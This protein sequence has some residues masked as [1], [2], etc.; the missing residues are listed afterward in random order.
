[1]I[2]VPVTESVVS[3]TLD[4]DVVFDVDFEV[5]GITSFKANDIIK[6][7]DEIMLI[8]NVGVGQTNNFK[9]L[10]AQL[11]TKVASHSNGTTVELLGGNYNIVDNTVHFVSA[12][13]GGI[14]IGT[15]TDGPDEIDW[16]GITTYSTFQGRTF[17]RSG[18]EDTDVDTYSSNYTFDNIQKDFNGQKN[19]F[20]LL[21]N[22][23]NVIG[24]AT[25]QAIVLNSNILQEPQGAQSTTGDFTLGEVAGVTSITYLGDSVSSEDDPNRATI[26]RG[27]TII[28]VASTPGLGF[29]PLIS[30]GA[31]CFVSAGGTITSISIGNSGSGYRTGVGTINVGYAVSSTGITTVVNIG[32]ATVQNGHVVAITTNYFGANLDQNYPPV[33]VIDAPLPYSSIP[34]VYNEGTTGIG[35]GAK[36]DVKVGQGSSIIEFEIVSGGFGYGVSEELRLSIGGTT[37]IQ[38]EGSGSFD[39]F[40][41][42]V[43][44]VYRDTFNGFTVGELDVFDKLDDQFDGVNRS[45]PLS[46]AGNLFAIETAEGSNINIAQCLIVTIN[47]I[48]QVPN[49]A[50]KFNG[51]SLIEF[52]EAPK[53]GDSSKIIF[54]KGTPDVDVVLV[55]ILETVKIGDTLQLKNDSSLGQGF[56]FFQ[57]ERIVTGITTLD[58]VRT[59]PY[60][61]PGITT[62]KSLVRPITWCK[63]IDDISVNGSFVTKDRVDY[64]PS[65]YPA[66]YITS[67]VGVNSTQVYTDTTRPFFNSSNETSLLDYQDR[68]TIVDQSSIVGAVA[69]VT[70]STAGTVTGFTLS[71]VGAGYSTAT[72]SI[73]QPIDI[74]GGTR[75]TATASV[76]AGGTI[77]G[78]TI[79]NA[80]AGYSLSNPPEVLISVPKSRRE[81][82]GVNSY[83]GDQGIIVG[84]A[85][86]SGALGT[87]ELYIPQ[88]SFMRDDDIVG[89]GI[90][91]S[92]LNADDLFVVNLSSFGLSTNTSDGIYRVSKAYDFVTDLNSV[93]LGTTAIRRVEVENVGFGATVAGFTR[94]KALGEY[95]WGKIQFKN[96]VA[97]NAL[98]FTPNGYSGLTTSPVVQ[99][100]RPLKFNNY[101]T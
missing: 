54:Y 69:T 78:F 89:T 28:S 85:Q 41:L 36:V 59:F 46:I 61:G 81:V 30:A 29:Q 86:S 98:T 57:E 25:N 11:G 77:S 88:D 87:L 76:S 72:V 84:Y 49:Q 7:D 27:G 58:T 44:D 68:I 18:I 83:F 60:D 51:G 91:L 80:G 42:T 4:Q 99:R 66:A 71:N 95:T 5:T 14:P 65:I 13:F 31:S 45:F 53:K 16:S 93:G 20:S 33:I 32:T 47:D 8:Q 100:L 63:Q 96:R 75:A 94:G 2:Q 38:T 9:V 17:M 21:Q 56:G 6:I 70:V 15:T 73:G 64:E 74:V 52:T 19:T 10:R 67:Y 35:T 92:T 43:T 3:T 12:P 50:Y 101:L 26:P 97:T 40:V 48:L 62:N 37:G 1:M 82:I 23:N 34:L 90:T 22:G 24:F 79:T 55:D 39:Q